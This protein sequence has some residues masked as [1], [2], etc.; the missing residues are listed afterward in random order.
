MPFSMQVNQREMLFTVVFQPIFDLEIN[1]V[2][3]MEVLSRVQSGSNIETTLKQISLNGNSR[4]FTL[5]LF[6]EIV[7]VCSLLPESIRYLSVNVTMAHMCNYRICD[8]L[9][10]LIT[11]LS[12]RKIKLVVELPEGEPSPK[13]KSRS[14]RMLAYNIKSL[15]WHGVLIAI[16]DFGQ[17]FHVDEA[18]V[19]RFMPDILK[20]DKK[21]VQEPNNNRDVWLLIESIRKR[22]N[23][24]VV[25]EGVEHAKDLDF[26]VGEGIQLCQ[27][28]YFGRPGSL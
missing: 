27:G 20:I 10:E 21:I 22:F 28:F 19:S 24:S 23:L 26:V 8:D 17:G 15:Q 12:E 5:A 2:I 25:A 18:V 7:S 1:T 4:E 11:R 13:P 16:D 6:K 14:G 9:E 3:A